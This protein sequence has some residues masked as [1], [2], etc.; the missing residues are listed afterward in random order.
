[1]AGVV[2][3]AALVPIA[4]PPALSDCRP[5]ET[6]SGAVP[7]VLDNMN[8]AAIPF[9]GQAAALVPRAPA[10]FSSSAM[11]MRSGGAA[12]KTILALHDAYGADIRLPSRIPPARP[13]PPKIGTAGNSRADIH[14]SCPRRGWRRR[15]TTLHGT[16]DY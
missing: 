9:G 2:S 10:A 4:H 7:S 3:E 14:A 6:R 8:S 12:R 1:M 5:P 11:G 16:N 13:Q 15:D